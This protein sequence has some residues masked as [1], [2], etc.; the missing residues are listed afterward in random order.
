M[1]KTKNRY[2]YPVKLGKNVKVTYDESPAH[3][4]RLKDAVDFIVPVGTPITAADK[5]VV[6]DVKDDS[7]ISGK[8][9]S[10]DKYGNY[11]EIKHANEEYSIYE[12]IR[13]NGSLVKKGDKVLKGQV[14][15]YSGNTGWIAHLGPHLHF[16]VHKYFGKEK[17]DYKT[18]KIIWE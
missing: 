7:D 13:K 4:G 15:G 9:K 1:V 10:Y 12:H 14:I 18:L 8:S 16:D 2:Q 6:V 17:E 5:G 3:A 11:I